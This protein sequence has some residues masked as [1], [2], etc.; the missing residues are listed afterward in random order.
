MQTDELMSGDRQPHDPS[1]LQHA[2]SIDPRH[3]RS[4]LHWRML[5][6]AGPLSGGGIAHAPLVHTRPRVSQFWQAWPPRPHVSDKDP[7]AHIVADVQQPLQ[8]AGPHPGGGPASFASIT[9]SLT[10]P[11]SA[12]PPPPVYP[13][14]SRMSEHAASGSTHSTSTPLPTRRGKSLV[15]R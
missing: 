8:V 15:I 9:A 3:G 14:Q 7:A 1:G 2:I 5:H 13:V 4:V 12:S 10:S 6:G 11:A